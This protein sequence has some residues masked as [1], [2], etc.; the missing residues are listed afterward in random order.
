MMV[1]V[2]GALVIGVTLGLLGSGGSILTVPLLTYVVSEPA[3]LAIAESLIIVGCIA[4]IG[5][6]RYQRKGLVTWPLLLKFG[7]PSMVGTYL[8]A[9]GSQFLLGQTQMVMFAVVM[10]LASYFMLKPISAKPNP[11]ANFI[12]V[13]PVA[14]TVGVV[15][16]LVGVGGGFLIVPALAI[17]LRIDM[18]KAVGTS[19]FIIAMQSAVGS[20]KYLYLFH[21]QGVSIHWQLV[22]VMTIVGGIGSVVGS[23]YAS[24]LPQ[25]ALKKGFGFALVL[26]ATSIV[27][28]QLLSVQG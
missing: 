28:Q 18:Q 27:L 17:I 25:Q 20:A 24:R 23:R 21:Q 5:G 8:G 15:A 14:V 11:R 19:L 2:L 10:L 6:W 3:K 7:V 12:I 22:I 1:I 13:L 4:L 16:G 9:W 26:I